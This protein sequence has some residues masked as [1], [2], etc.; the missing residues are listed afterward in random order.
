MSAW[1]IAGAVLWLGFATAAPTK[2]AAPL[3]SYQQQQVYSLSLKSL[4]K[5]A[6]TSTASQL[7][8]V[9][10][11]RL[12]AQ[13]ALQRYGEAALYPAQ[14]VAYSRQSLIEQAL[15]Q[16]LYQLC[17]QEIDSKLG[18]EP[19]QSLVTWAKA[20]WQ[21]QQQQLDELFGKDQQL[22]LEYRLSPAQFAAAQN[23][24]VLRYQLADKTRK[25]S[26]AE[27][28]QQFNVQGRVELFRANLPFIQQ[29]ALQVLFAAYV[30]EIA[31]QHWS[32]QEIADLRV[33]LAAQIDLQALAELYGLPEHSDRPSAILQALQRDIR[34]AEI[35]KYYHAHRQNF[36]VIH[37]IKARH[38]QLRDE[39]LV[40][41]VRLALQQNTDFASLARQYSSAADAS[42][43]GDLGWRKAHAG[44]DWLSQFALL[45]TPG[46]PSAAVLAP[47]VGTNDRYW[48]IVLV[49]QQ[50]QGYAELQSMGVQDQI[51]QTLARAK[52]QAN[53]GRWRQ[54]LL[55]QSNFKIL[56]DPA[57]LN[58]IGR[59]VAGRS[60]P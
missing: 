57:T 39:K 34:A 43:G 36:K 56:V 20:E 38:I 18:A 48:E 52:A 2:A 53:L 4:S 11:D 41:T 35:S 14:T 54:Q 59:Q 33:S 24:I 23:I 6:E 13:A 32:A 60:Q 46:Q 19:A 26:L 12:L 9:V 7:Q 55:A 37:Q 1:L 15:T 8:Q 21:I 27:L 47:S 50:R 17:R 40:Q 44:A 29:Q 58:Q 5:T 22:Q 30:H 3:A 42:Q 45:Q 51:R 16:Q 31:R 28:S 25:L 10:A 49:E